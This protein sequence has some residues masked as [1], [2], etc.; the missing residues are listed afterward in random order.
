MHEMY[1]GIL[2]GI[3]LA[4][5]CTCH[6]IYNILFYRMIQ[7]KS[8][9]TVHSSPFFLFLPSSLFFFFT[10]STAQIHRTHPRI[11]RPNLAA[12]RHGLARKRVAAAVAIAGAIAV[13]DAAGFLAIALSIHAAVLPD[14][15]LATVV[16]GEKCQRV[17]AA[18]AFEDGAEPDL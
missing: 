5:T 7:N 16:Y 18:L 4:V 6:L 9:S 14:L 11:R 12:I 2:D 13:H 17:R 3:N 10:G 15:E 8:H 1:L